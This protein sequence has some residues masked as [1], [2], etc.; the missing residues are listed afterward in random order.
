MIIF[1]LALGKVSG[2]SLKSKEAVS[3]K[4]LDLLYFS[5]AYLIVTT[6]KI[7]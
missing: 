7:S 3:L 2:N 5:D 6:N 4:Y 1:A